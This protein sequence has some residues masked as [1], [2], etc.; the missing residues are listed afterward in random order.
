MLKRIE[1][2]GADFFSAAVREMELF[3]WEW[4][5]WG[6]R[7]KN[8]W[9]DA[10]LER[11]L[12]PCTRVQE[13]LLIG[14]L[15]PQ[16]ILSLLANSRP[17][18][19][20]LVMDMQDLSLDFAPPLF[21]QLTHMVIGEFNRNDGLGNVMSDNWKHW[22]TICRLR[23]L[24]H[25]ALVHTAPPSLIH[26][27]CRDAPQLEILLFLAQ[28]ARG[29]ALASEQ[30]ILH[31]WRLV[32]LALSD[33]EGI[34]MSSLSRGI[35]TLWTQADEF[36]GRKRR[37]LIEPADYYMIPS[38]PCIIHSET[39]TGVHDQAPEPTLPSIPVPSDPE[40]LTLPDSDSEPTVQTEGGIEQDMSSEEPEVWL[41]D[42]DESTHVE[43]PFY[44]V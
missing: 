4:A 3:A 35:N 30:L 5:I 31:D 28:D 21:Q 27:I 43:V 11:V 36:V 33:L 7:S 42:L 26:K 1:V 41:L 37:G 29:V 44:V 17:K 12:R 14:E 8:V 25:L 13:L 18:R 23:A 2:K 40:S 20:I 24:T 22:P 19:L 6:V 9:S 10:E 16:R 15:P 34:D 39:Y 32:I 38:L